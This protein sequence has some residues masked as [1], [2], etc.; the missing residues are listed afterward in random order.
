MCRGKKKNLG[1]ADLLH[2]AGSAHR[3]DDLRHLF[4]VVLKHRVPDAAPDDLGGL[5]VLGDGLR[6]HI[7]TAVVLI[8]KEN[9]AAAPAIA[10]AKVM[11]RR[12][13]RLRRTSADLPGCLPGAAGTFIVTLS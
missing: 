13:R 6:E 12:K 10:M 4:A 8:T 11:P 5:L 3:L 1:A 7:L 9:T 2:P